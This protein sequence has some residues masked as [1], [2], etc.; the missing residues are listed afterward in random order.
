M[1]DSELGARELADSA[2]LLGNGKADGA[3]AGGTDGQATTTS[4][5]V[6]LLNTILGTGMLAMPHAF[7]SGG[8]IPGLLTAAWCGL[9]AALGL[10]LLSRA[11]HHVAAQSQSPRPASFSSLA[12]VTF[13]SASKVFD[14]AIFLKCFGVSISYL[15]IIGSLMPKSIRAFVPSEIAAPERLYEDRRLWIL[16][17][18]FV[19]V[20][21]GFYRRLD[22]L[23]F[24]SYVAL[25]AVANLVR[26][27]ARMPS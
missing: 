25:C 10:Y 14:A 27:R 20:P 26:P 7:A 21:L 9:T 8:L 19:L 15:I 6:L 3:P 16:L 24:I 4:A 12:A 17:S 11:A 18:M 5:T 13:P 23:K 1:E 22:S 2:P